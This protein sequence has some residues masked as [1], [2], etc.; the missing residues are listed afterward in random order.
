MEKFAL[1]G[2]A[3]SVA[4]ELALAGAHVALFCDRWGDPQ[5]QQNRTGR[6]A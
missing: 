3:Q 1:P 5:S 2:L 6:R 4:R